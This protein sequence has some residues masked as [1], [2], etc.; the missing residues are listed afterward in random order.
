MTAS[1][2]IFSF[3][4]L[5]DGYRYNTDVYDTE[6]PLELM[7]FCTPSETDCSK[8]CVDLN[9]IDADVLTYILL[10][11]SSNLPIFYLPVHPHSGQLIAILCYVRT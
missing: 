9:C 6:S 3:L 2:F 8:S 10:K 5:L 4:Q 1:Q 7:S 11:L